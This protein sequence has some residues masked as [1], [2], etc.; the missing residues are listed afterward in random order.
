MNSL[1]T[2]TKTTQFRTI[3][4]KTLISPLGRFYQSEEHFPLSSIDPIKQHLD[5]HLLSKTKP[6]KL[7][8]ILILRGFCGLVT[9]GPLPSDPFLKLFL[10]LFEV[11]G[12]FFM[13]CLEGLLIFL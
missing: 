10:L 3:K 5:I 2:H 4:I 9:H 7:L 12:H 13:Y 11:L 8:V 6:S 1:A